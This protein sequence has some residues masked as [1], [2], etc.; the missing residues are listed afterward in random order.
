MEVDHPRLVELEAGIEREVSVFGKEPNLPLQRPQ[1]PDA[2]IESGRARGVRLVVRRPKVGG[3]SC[4]GDAYERTDEEM[5]LQAAL[6]ELLIPPQWIPNHEI[7]RQT[8]D[9]EVKFG[10]RQGTPWSDCTV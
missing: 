10:Q 3:V 2:D 1:Q 6:W 8:E 9:L 4:R 7:D 5:G